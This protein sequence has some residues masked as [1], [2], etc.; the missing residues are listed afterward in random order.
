V[1]KIK[2]EKTFKEAVEKRRISDSSRRNIIIPGFNRYN[3]QIGN[4]KY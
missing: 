3:F 4:R 1:K 2:K